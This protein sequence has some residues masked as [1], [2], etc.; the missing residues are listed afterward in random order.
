MQKNTIIS[1]II[2]IALIGGTLYFVSD[3]SPA[4]NENVSMEN[5]KQIITVDAKGRYS[6]SATLAKADVPTILR[7]R[8]NGTFDCTAAFTIPAINYQKNLPPSGVTEIEL[9][10][11]KVGSTLKGVCAMGMYNFSV[12][13]N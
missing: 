12:N 6:P 8:T 4:T 9:P 1:I 2:S 7:M 5:G 10:P 3:R 13:F 11:Q